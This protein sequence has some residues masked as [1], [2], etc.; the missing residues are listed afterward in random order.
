MGCAAIESIETGSPHRGFPEARV[1]PRGSCSSQR[2]KSP[3]KWEFRRSRS[4]SS[5]PR[6][7]LPATA[8]LPVRPVSPRDHAPEE[9]LP[10][11][12]SGRNRNEGDSSDRSD[13]DKLVGKSGFEPLKAYASRFTV[14]PLW[15]LGYLPVLSSARTVFRPYRRPLVPSTSTGPPAPRHRLP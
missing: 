6:H 8:R 4:T 7:W 11:N 10:K 1:I 2:L 14:C 5:R 15:P 3:S 13:D 12:H 9:P